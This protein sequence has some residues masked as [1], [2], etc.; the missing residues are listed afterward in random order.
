MS[1]HAD[2]PHLLLHRAAQHMC[3]AP[4]G[5]LSASVYHDAHV[6]WT[7]KEREVF[8]S[9]VHKRALCIAFTRGYGE[10]DDVYR[11]MM[12]H[13]DMDDARRTVL[14]LRALTARRVAWTECAVMRHI[15]EMLPGALTYPWAQL[16]AEDTALADLAL[17]RLVLQH[18]TIQDV[19]ADE[20]DTLSLAPIVMYR[21]ASPADFMR[22][23]PLRHSARFTH[24]QTQ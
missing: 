11:I 15:C 14:V 2:E 7:W 5:T 9:F 22:G 12:R 6:P 4:E 20:M 8:V 21:N 10:C 24:V 17:T 19:M 16:S 18:D 3:M 1:L 13:A 23:L